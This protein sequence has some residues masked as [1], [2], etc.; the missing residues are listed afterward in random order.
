FP[1]YYSKQSKDGFLSKEQIFPMLRYLGKKQFI[2]RDRSQR[3][4]ITEKGRGVLIQNAFL[5]FRNVMQTITDPFILGLL[6]PQT[7]VG[8]FDTSEERVCLSIEP[9]TFP[10]FPSSTAKNRVRSF[11]KGFFYL[12]DIGEIEYDEISKREQELLYMQNHMNSLT[13]D[14]K[15]IIG[16]LK[17]KKILCLNNE[18][19]LELEIQP[20]TVDHIIVQYLFSLAKDPEAALNEM[21]KVLKEGQTVLMLEY[22]SDQSL[23]QIYKNQLFSSSNIDLPKVFQ[24]ILNPKTPLTKDYIIS[25]INKTSFEILEVVDVPN[26]PRFLLRKSE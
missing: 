17:E 18:N 1:K 8:K 10:A 6:P 19:K 14:V 3:W 21:Y 24:R 23:F 5:T 7:S 26:L 16:E 13:A 22:T 25:I 9:L 2:K 11:Q 15:T 12:V 20:N 4:M